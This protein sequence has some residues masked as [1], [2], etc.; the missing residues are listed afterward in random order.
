[1]QYEYLILSG[2][3][4]HQNNN[5]KTHLIYYVYGADLLIC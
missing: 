3:W 2:M 1:M 4:N 5:N